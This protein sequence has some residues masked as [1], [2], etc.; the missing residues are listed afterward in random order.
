MVRSD[1]PQVSAYSSRQWALALAIVAS[2]I[3]VA[4]F[5]WGSLLND[6]ALKELHMNLMRV[7][8][9]GFSGITIGG[10]ING[11]IQSTAWGLGIGWILAASLNMLSKK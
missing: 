6:P 9:P 8:F 5:F 10:F 11:F 4:C 1:S 7:S 2:S 3:F